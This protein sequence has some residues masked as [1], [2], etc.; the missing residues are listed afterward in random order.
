MTKPLHTG[1]AA[2]AAIEAARLAGRGFTADA[3]VL[4]GPQG[5][6]AVYGRGGCSLTED[7][8]ASLGRRWTLVDDGIFVKR[9]PCCYAVHRPVAALQA[10]LEETGV[11]RDA[12]VSVAI[13]DR[14]SKR[15]N[16]SH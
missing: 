1:D 2:R 8:L 10:L 11:D 13:G 9:W 16:S 3:S 4:D 14:K 12:I 5:F 7:S 6:P 15:L